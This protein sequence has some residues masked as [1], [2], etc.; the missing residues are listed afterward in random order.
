MKLQSGIKLQPTWRF[1]KY[2]S[3]EHFE[4][5]KHY[6]KNEIVGNLLLNEGI[7]AL[8]NLLIGAAETA[9]SNANSYIGVGDSATAANATQTG[10]IAATN[11]LYKAVE[12]TYP[13]IAAQ[14]TTWRAIMGSGDANWAWNEFTVASGSSDAADNLNRLVSAQG[15]K[16][17]GQVWTVDLDILWS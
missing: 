14:T 4:N 12:A 1:T 7:T 11:K 9:F 6:E 2:K 15:T 3:Q 5:G 10:L 16:V 8:Q 13:L 17:T